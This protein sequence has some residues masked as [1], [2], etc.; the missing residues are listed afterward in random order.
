MS[1]FSGL[2]A[3]GGG[4]AGGAGSRFHFR[5]AAYF[6]ALAIGARN[7]GDLGLPGTRLTSIRVETEASVDDVLIE[8]DAGGYVAIQAKTTLDCQTSVETEFGKV[9]DQFVR[10]WLSAQSGRA[11]YGWNRPLDPSRDRLVLLVSPEAS[12]T[13]RN[14]LRN[15]LD[16]HRSGAPLHVQPKKRMEALSTFCTLLTLAWEK[17]AR[18]TPTDD[19]LKQLLNVCA[20]VTL[21]LSDSHMRLAEEALRTELKDPDEAGLAFQALSDYQAVQVA[22]RGGANVVALRRALAGGN[23]TENAKIVL[24]RPKRRD[25]LGMLLAWIACHLN[26]YEQWRRLRDTCKWADGIVAVDEI[27]TRP[28]DA[29]GATWATGL[30]IVAALLAQMAMFCVLGI[31]VLNRNWVVGEYL[32]TAKVVDVFVYQLRHILLGAMRLRL[33]EEGAVFLA[34]AATELLVVACYVALCSIR[35]KSGPPGRARRQFA[36]YMAAAALFKLNAVSW[37]VAC[38]AFVLSLFVPVSWLRDFIVTLTLGSLGV[39]IVSTGVWMVAAN[40]RRVR[41]AAG[42]A[43]DYLVPV[44]SSWV[45]AFGAVFAVLLWTDRFSQAFEPR[46]AIR[47]ND[48]C[49]SAPVG[50]TVDILPENLPGP[51]VLDELHLNLGVRFA[52]AHGAL[53]VGPPHVASASFRLQRSSTDTQPSYVKEDGTSHGV[54]AAPRFNCP[55]AWQGPGGP[56]LLILR[57]PVYTSARLADAPSLD[58]QINVRVEFDNYFASLF[59]SA[60]SGCSFWP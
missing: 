30:L 11:E 39:C 37:I 16:V 13:I 25:A 48:A 43:K 42:G 22:L 3:D 31:N 4:Q 40:V 21:D 44:A 2:L 12:G 50:C 54:V 41:R 19:E 10:Y 55:S 38:C 1:T 32:G 57:N 27:D 17:H 29:V 20:V 26:P 6:S 58:Y 59:R 15:M 35:V 33:T 8:T 7:L 45:V 46:L 5:V 60:D 51:I 18:T 52:D 36:T 56:K 34:S 47:L 9:A 49:Y 23:G 14:H 53:I 24:L 28:R